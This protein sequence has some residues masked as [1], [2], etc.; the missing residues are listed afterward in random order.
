MVVRKEKGKRPLP[1]RDLMS[2]SSQ[3][4]ELLGYLYSGAAFS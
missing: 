4:Y 1:L 2:K 3:D